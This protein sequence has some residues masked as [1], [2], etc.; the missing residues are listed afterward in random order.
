MV[1]VTT[2][3]EQKNKAAMLETISNVIK[4]VTWCSSR[5]VVTLPWRLMEMAGVLAP[6]APR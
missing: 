2:T 5:M 1:E 3:G 6:P 4:F